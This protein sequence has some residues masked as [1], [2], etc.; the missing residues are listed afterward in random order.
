MDKSFSIMYEEFKQGIANLIN[1]SG[2]PICVVE[3]VLQNYL[4]EINA[5]A[6][7]QYQMD[8]VQYEKAL[9]EINKEEKES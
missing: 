4:V 3:S 6:K 7:N 8:K 9:N 2:L 1:N 5:I